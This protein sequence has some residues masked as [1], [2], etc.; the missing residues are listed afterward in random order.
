MSEYGPS[1]GFRNKANITGAQKLP[2]PNPDCECPRIIQ[3][4]Y[5][6]TGHILECHFPIPCS[7]ADCDYY[8]N[9]QEGDA[10]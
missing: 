2:L 9:D 7:E 6:L 8:R 4:M 3:A 5:C 1:A 10:G